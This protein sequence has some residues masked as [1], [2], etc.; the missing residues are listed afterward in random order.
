MASELASVVW[1]LKLNWQICSHSSEKY[2]WIEILKPWPPRNMEFANK[3]FTVQAIIFS[4]NTKLCLALPQIF[5]K[6]FAH[7]SK[8]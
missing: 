8:H 3:N 5:Q 6:G 1:L 7:K 4:K 2:V